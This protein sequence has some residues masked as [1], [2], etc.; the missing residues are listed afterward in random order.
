MPPRSGRQ[1]VALE[2][3]KRILLGVDGNESGDVAVS[4]AIALARRYSSDVRVVHVNQFLVGGRG[5]TVATREEAAGVVDTAVRA[6]VDAGVRA[7]GTLATA[8]CFDVGTRIA[9]AAH[10]WS[11]D[12]IVL[13][14]RRRRWL[15]RLAG[16]GMGDL[17]RSATALPVLTAPP[18]LKV[19]SG[20]GLKRFE[21]PAK[22]L[23]ELPKISN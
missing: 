4:F 12:V 11:A 23:P 18:P 3:F 8:N 15:R 6:L 10:E 20:R 9:D 17:V 21:V 1:E 2:M 5:F 19:I 7:D 14:S 13:G 22:T 16:P